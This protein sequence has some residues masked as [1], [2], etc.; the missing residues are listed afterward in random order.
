MG[1]SF[2]LSLGVCSA[3]GRGILDI[4]V[5]WMG[6]DFMIGYVDRDV[7]RESAWPVAVFLGW[8]R[9]GGISVQS[10]ARVWGV[11]RLPQWLGGTLHWIGG[12]DFMFGGVCL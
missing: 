3:G 9:I 2:C 7:L 12:V 4:A 8:R 1:A 10:A 6:L 11:V 5:N